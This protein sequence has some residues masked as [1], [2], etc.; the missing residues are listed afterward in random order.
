MKTSLKQLLK[1][2]NHPTWVMLLIGS[3]VLLLGIIFTHQ[4]RPY[5]SDDVSWQNILTT[6]TPLN[7]HQ[8]SL[9]SSNNFVSKIPYFALLESLLPNSRSL[10]L[11]E[12][13]LLALAG[14]ALFFY[15]AVYF[16]KKSGAKPSYYNLLPLV[17]IGSLGYSFSQLF[18]DPIW[19]GFE[20]GASFAL[21]VLL[22][23]LFYG[24]LSWK[25]WSFKIGAPFL[26]L[27]LGVMIY[28]DPYFLYFTVG[29]AVLLSLVLYGVRKI[30]LGKLALMA[31]VT[32]GS[33]IATKITSLVTHSVGIQ[34]ST[35]YPVEFIDFDK[36]FGNIAQ[37]L[38]GLLVIFGANFF[39]HKAVGAIA[40]AALFNFCILLLVLYRI[41]TLK[42]TTR[43]EWQNYSLHNWWIR[44]FIVLAAGNF[45]LYCIS[46][47]SVDL[48]TYRYLF[49][50]VYALVLLASLLVIDIKKYQ[51]LVAGFFIAGTLSGLY[52]SARGVSGYLQPGAAGNERN[53]V[54]FQ[55]LAELEKRHLT[56]GYANF[57]QAGINTYLSDNRVIVL[58]AT[59]PA[60][61]VQPFKWLLDTENY[62]LPAKKSF[63]IIDPAIEDQYACTE[64]ALSTQLGKPA[65]QV[66]VANRHILIYNYDVVSKM[67]N[68]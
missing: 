8:V 59:C 16:I 19:R 6:W 18:M 51:F 13:S 48:N 32:A 64:T 37:G 43:F 3:C 44:F 39:G 62:D 53:Q 31:G 65:E 45:I 5:N 30:S 20:T 23:K 42:N 41:Y 49:M 29:P 36:L 61:Q 50:L 47:V 22:A 9:G 33:F 4:T 66:S 14:Y 24:E 60:G 68:N 38:H 28:S 57:W 56:K 10:L 26:S 55:I 63:F 11:L 52:L 21:F 12:S 67:V 40:I 7:D 17:W 46:T 34:M 15:S 27:V 54:N 25:R 35:S 58:P 2:L 1:K